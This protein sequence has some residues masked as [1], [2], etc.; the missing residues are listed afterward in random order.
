H[1]VLGS[2]VFYYYPPVAFFVASPFA[3]AGLSTYSAII[4][5]F[6]VGYA[7]SGLTMYLWLK[8]QAPLPLLGAIVF[9][10]APYHAF[11]FYLRG[12]VAEF[13][14]IA[15]LPFVMLGLRRMIEDRPGGFVITALGYAALIG[16]HLPFA[17][18]A[19][20]F[21]IAPY[22]L[23]SVRGRTQTLLRV[24]AALA[25]G[26]V[27]AS[28]YLVPALLLDRYRDAAVLWKNPYLQP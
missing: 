20:V 17:V 15:C 2:P 13:F 3:L 12:A 10:I 8:D 4:A 14:A 18:L 16:S 1:G 11:D 27:L 7:V 28:I 23:V 6:F 19:S 5:A 26:L 24:G 22:L 9:M 25:L 21:L